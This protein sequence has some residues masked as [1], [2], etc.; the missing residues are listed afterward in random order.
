MEHYAPDCSCLLCGKTYSKRGLTRH[1]KACLQKR[2]AP[3]GVSGRQTSFYLQVTPGTGSNYFLHLL[4]SYQATLEDLDRFL[5]AIWLECCGHMS[6]FSYG[7][8][9]DEIPMAKKIRHVLAPGQVLDYQYD[10]GSTTEL[11][12]KLVDTAQGGTQKGRTVEIL[13]RNAPPVFPCDD[14]GEEKAAWICQ[15]CGGPESGWLCE[16]CIAE[17]GCDEEMLV[18]LANSPRAGV[19]GYTGELEKA[20][21]SE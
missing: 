5:R 17:H 13:A 15:E 10:F 19:C 21:L 11:Q 8:W 16:A 1:I 3:K 7:Q 14:C 6:A 9:G 20:Y 2:P 4:V 12:I 18:P